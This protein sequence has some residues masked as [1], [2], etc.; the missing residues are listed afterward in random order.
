MELHLYFTLIQD[1]GNGYT[2]SNNSWDFVTVYLF[3]LIWVTVKTEVP[4]AT[5]PEEKEDNTR[6][7]CSTSEQLCFHWKMIKQTF[8]E[9]WKWR[10]FDW[11]AIKLMHLFNFCFM[12]VFVLCSAKTEAS[13]WN[14]LEC[15]HF[16][17]CTSGVLPYHKFINRHFF[18]KLTN[19]VSLKRGEYDNILTKKQFPSNEKCI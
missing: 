4:E 17:F 11:P 7:R 12:F 18:Q 6:L 1:L 3:C 19:C 5:D 15:R 13:F 2:A 10:Q 8:S 9:R 14:M 16:K